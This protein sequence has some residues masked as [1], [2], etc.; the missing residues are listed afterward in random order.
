MASVRPIL[1]KNPQNEASI[2]SSLSTTSNS[3]SESQDERVLNQIRSG[4]MEKGPSDERA[5]EESL[6]VAAT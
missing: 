4:K 5:G 1:D 2:S 3:L 6:R